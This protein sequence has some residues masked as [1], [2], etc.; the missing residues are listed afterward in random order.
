MNNL[1]LPVTN[2]PLKNFTQLN[3][4]TQVNQAMTYRTV[5]DHCRY[6]SPVAMINPNTSHGYALKI[7]IVEREIS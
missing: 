1:P 5:S 6:Y 3:Y 2:D 4:L 7:C